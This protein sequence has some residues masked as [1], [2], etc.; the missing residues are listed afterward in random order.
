MISKFQRL[1]DFFPGEVIQHGK[2][3]EMVDDV[4][5]KKRKRKGLLLQKLRGQRLDFLTV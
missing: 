1:R 5:F 4:E 3:K 2:L